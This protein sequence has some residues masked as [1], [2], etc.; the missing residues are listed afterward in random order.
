M[1]PSYCPDIQCPTFHA[2]ISLWVTPRLSK[3]FLAGSVDNEGLL[4]VRVRNSL[5]R[6]ILCSVSL[7]TSLNKSSN[8]FIST[9]LVRPSH[10]QRVRISAKSRKTRRNEC[11]AYSHIQHLNLSAPTLTD[12]FFLWCLHFG[13]KN[14]VSS[15]DI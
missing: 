8:E 3:Y 7:A 15:P 12:N 10:S 5:G 6:N 11:P 1:R 13:Q 2:N 9:R 14:N 4:L